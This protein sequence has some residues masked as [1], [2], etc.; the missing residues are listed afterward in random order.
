[1]Q[2]FKQFLVCDEIGLFEPIYMQK[3]MYTDPLVS[4]NAFISYRL[5]ILGAKYFHCIHMYSGLA[6]GV[7][8]NNSLILQESKQAV[9]H[10]FCVKKVSSR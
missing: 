7:S 2:I 5:R 10:Q 8:K 4:I 3:F 1:M 9:D 6:I